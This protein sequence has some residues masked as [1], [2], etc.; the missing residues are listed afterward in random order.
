MR[1]RLPIV[2]S[3]TRNQ[4]IGLPKRELERVPKYFK[5]SV[6]G[7]K[8]KANQ[9][10][11][12]CCEDVMIVCDGHGSEGGS[13]SSFVSQKLLSKSLETQIIRYN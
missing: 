13:I 6:G 4:D 11:V 3:E 8:A 5:Y 9:D 1:R 2:L 12:V 7:H 10:R